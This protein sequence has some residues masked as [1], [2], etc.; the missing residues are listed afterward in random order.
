MIE[1][2]Y[3]DYKYNDKYR[4]TIKLSYNSLLFCC[5]L[6]VKSD[7]QVQFVANRSQLYS[8][9]GLIRLSFLLGL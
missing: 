4:N 3:F 5:I 7:L 1:L 6:T 2:S 8:F 9:D